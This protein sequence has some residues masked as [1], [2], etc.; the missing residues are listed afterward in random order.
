ML[1]FTATNVPPG[2]FAFEQFAIY[3]D[4]RGFY[5]QDYHLQ[6]EDL[7]SQYQALPYLKFG[8]AKNLDLNIIA[9]IIYSASRRSTAFSPGDTSVLAGIQLMESKGHLIP[10]IRLLVGES[11]PTGKYDNLDPG[12]LLGDGVGT[13]SFETIFLLSLSKIFYFSEKHAFRLNPNFYLYIP[14]STRISGISVHSGG[15]FAKGVAHPGLRF[16]F[17]LPIEINVT[18][19]LFVGT[20]VFFVANR[21]SVFDPERG[22][23]LKRG[24]PYSNNLSIAPCIEYNPSEKFGMEGAVWLSVDGKNTFAFTSYIG[25]MWFYF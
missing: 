24:L 16:A 12:L 1:S 18:N 7:F 5:G 17:D 10:D 20:D 11:F 15:L 25:M 8:I 6:S 3:T 23:V 21:H 14:T 13:G 2:H 19:N 22:S 9:S 4:T